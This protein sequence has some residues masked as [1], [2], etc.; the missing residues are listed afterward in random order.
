L[1][2]Q[3]EFPHFPQFPLTVFGLS[4]APIPRKIA[5]AFSQ[6]LAIELH[7]AMNMVLLLLGPPVRGDKADA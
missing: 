6:F 2:R 4:T 5:R 3:N 7:K 1:E